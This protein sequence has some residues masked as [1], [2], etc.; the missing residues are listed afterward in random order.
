MTVTRRILL[1]VALGAAL[2][3][4]VVTAVTYKLVYD[5]MTKQDLQHLETYV[6]ERA[7]REEARFQQ[8]QANLQLVRGLF[9]TRLELPLE[10][11]SLAAKWN[12]WYLHYPDGAWRTREE[13]SDARKYSSL[14][15]HLN[16]RDTPNNRKQ[17][18][19]ARNLCDELLPGWVDSFPSIF[20]QFHGPV[21]IGFDARLPTWVWEMPADY[22]STGLEW[23]EVALP[24]DP[25]RDGFSWT[26]VQQD[27]V[28]HF[29]LVSV[30]LPLWRH[31]EF[32]GSIV[33]EI[34]S[35]ERC[36]MS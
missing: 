32:I 11:A 27:S 28:V 30:F 13:F 9:L 5:A 25:P 29:P 35:W 8:V 23:V 31:G 16:W 33:H 2:V 20:F 24:A 34:S 18:I 1:H 4:A 7:Q 10:D 3:V 17:I 19:V 15:T 26:G 22:D 21:T 36:S 12:H 6:A 14:W